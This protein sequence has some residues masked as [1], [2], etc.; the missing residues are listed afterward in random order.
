V[1]HEDFCSDPSAVLAGTFRFLEVDPDVA[2]KTDLA[3]N[4]S[5]MPRC[6]ALSRSLLRPNWLTRAI[7]PLVPPAARLPLETAA[8][9][10][11]SIP[12]AIPMDSRR[13]L[14]REYSADV[15]SLGKLV[16]RDLSAWLPPAPPKP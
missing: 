3:I 16:G 15:R 1:L 8:K 12:T 5:G 13:A 9:R 7:R 6:Y 14:E 2:V 4:Q 11:L 10:L